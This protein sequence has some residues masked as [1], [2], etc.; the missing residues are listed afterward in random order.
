MLILN[1]G[2]KYLDPKIALITALAFPLGFGIYELIQAKKLNPL[3]VFGILNVGISGGLTLAGL[4]GIWFAIKEATF[5][6]LIGAFVFYSAYTSKPFIQ[7]LILNPSLLKV[8]ELNSI[9]DARNETQNFVRLQKTVTQWLAG[10]FLLSAVLNFSLAVHIF[11]PLAPT[12]SETERTEALN[13]QLAQMTSW[14]F[15]VIMAPS[16]I[17]LGLILWYLFRELKKMTGQSIE[18]LLIDS[19]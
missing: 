3:S 1:K 9:L 11:Q 17:F 18:E 14:S 4:G 19:K 15:P 13:Q 8:D 12:L 16:M 10:S 2:S 6:T 5:P 7:Q